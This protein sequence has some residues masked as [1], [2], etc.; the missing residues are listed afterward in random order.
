M[1]ACAVQLLSKPVIAAIAGH[2]VAG[3]LELACWCDLR[4]VEDDAIMGVFCRFVRFPVLPQ[5]Q[6]HA[7]RVFG[8]GLSHPTPFAPHALV[9]LACSPSLTS[10]SHAPTWLLA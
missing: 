5:Q 3:G 9:H 7:P 8:A 2:A 4:V 10:A 1:W 6:G